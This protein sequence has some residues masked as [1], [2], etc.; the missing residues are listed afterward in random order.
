[1]RKTIEPYLKLMRID[2]PIGTFLLLWPTLWALWLAGNGQPDPTIVLWFVLGTFVMR[3]AGC[4]INDYADRDFDR[5]V[6][7]TQAR[8]LTRGDISER[9][10][11]TL[12][13][14]LLCIALFIV[15]Q[16][17]SFT[18]WF[19][20][21]AVPIAASYPFFKRITHLPQLVLGVAF[22]WGIPMAYAALTES[23]PFEA[24]LLFAAN[25]SWIVAYD[26]QYA[27][28]DREDD[29]KVGIKSTAILFGRHDNLIIGGLHGLCLL[30]LLWLGVE[31]DFS[32][33]YYLGL[34]AAA[35]FAIYQQTL[36]RDRDRQRCFQAFLNNIWFGAMV[37][38]GLLLSLIVEH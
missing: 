33:H 3:S 27:M 1:M 2:R 30:L 8:P 9:Q 36:C 25:F 22:S 17:N 35:C 19:A 34:A 28:A 31:R 4:V 13:V 10:A 15:L 11:L 18:F 6:D 24:W 12:F 5:H 21:L 38:A 16:L 7:R 23:V 26:T 37:F 20:L 14:A 32:Y 29:I